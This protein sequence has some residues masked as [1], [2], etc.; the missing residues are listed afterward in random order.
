MRKMKSI[1]RADDQVKGAVNGLSNFRARYVKDSSEYKFE[2]NLDQDL[3]I[4]I[5]LP[6]ASGMDRMRTEA[7]KGPSAEEQALEEQLLKQL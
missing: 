5:S 7:D 6:G 1:V 3:L 4:P 2:H